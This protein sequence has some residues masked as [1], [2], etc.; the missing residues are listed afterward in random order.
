MA[1]ASFPP[2]ARV[3]VFRALMLGDLLCAVPALRALSCAW[4]AARITLVGLP[5]ARDLVRRLPYLHDFIEFPGAPGLPERVLE[6][7]RWPA[8]VSAARAQRFDLAIQLHGSGERTNPILE[9]LGATRTAG[10]FPAGQTGPDP[11]TWL[12]WPEHLPEP[13]RLL[14]LAAHLGAP[15]RGEHLELPV[16]PEE[17][18]A[19][20]A[21]RRELPIGSPGYACIHPGARLAS[22][23]WPPERF[24]LVGDRLA[25]AGFAV[26][27]TGSAEEAPLI[28]EVRA[29]M[30]APAIELAGRT[31]LGLLAA[32]VGEARLVVCNDTGISHVAAAQGTP[33]VVVSCGGDPVRWQPLDVRR[34][35]VL[36]HAVPCRPCTHEHCPIGH[37]CALGVDAEAVSEQ[38]LALVA[39][40]EDEH[41][42]A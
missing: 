11:A 9:Q 14:A 17:R 29:A 34:H 26:V 32:L 37:E 21:L 20:A 36:W 22:R 15:P 27:L 10:F 38:A 6:G 25:R 8:F 2:P 19:F 33:S 16:L 7:W 39:T 42:P 41:V 31:P 4:P 23:R 13:R 18:Q 35:R 40:L 30:R 12:P 24:A 28:A 3:A 1:T 5:W